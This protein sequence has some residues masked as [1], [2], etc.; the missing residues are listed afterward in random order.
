MNGKTESGMAA[1]AVVLLFATESTSPG[2]PQTSSVGAGGQAPI[3]LTRE[4]GHFGVSAPATS[5]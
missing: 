4:R 5:E 1:R 2:A 3:R